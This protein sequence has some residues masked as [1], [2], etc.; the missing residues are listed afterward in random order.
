MTLDEAIEKYEAMSE[1][2][3]MRAGFETDNP[4]YAMSESER[5]A[6]RESAEESRQIAGWLK[7]LKQLRTALEEIKEELHTP[8]RGTCD[9]FILDRIDEIIGEYEKK[10]EKTH[11][12]IKIKNF[13]P[14]VT[15][16]FGGIRWEILDN[17]FP[18]IYGREG[19]FCLAKDV[20]FTKAF[21][22]NGSNNWNDS[23]LRNYLNHNF[24]N[25]LISKI[26]EDAL[27][28]FERDLSWRV[29]YV[30]LISFKE[31]TRYRDYI[32]DKADWW[33]TNT[34]SSFNS[35]AGLVHTGGSL[36]YNNA[37]NKYGGVVPVVCINP[38][39]KVDVI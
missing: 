37:F 9:Y 27:L 35:L 8:N 29:D 19:V 30:S 2:L 12:M 11:C 14:G 38:S 22:E 17:R 1:E 33:W 15:V 34:A 13:D 5:K 7:D 24:K 20:Q 18:A 16:E 21:D 10:N 6:Y 36:D 28:P 25:E 39:F 26:G 23:T 32:T 4:T 31:Y 3:V